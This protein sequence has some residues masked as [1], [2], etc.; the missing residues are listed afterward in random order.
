MPRLD[1]LRLDVLRLDV[2][3]LDVPR[4]DVLRLD[5]RSDASRL[6][7]L[8]LDIAGLDVWELGVLSR[9]WLLDPGAALGGSAPDVMG[10]LRR[11]VLRGEDLWLEELALERSVEEDWPESGRPV[12]TFDSG[13]IMSLSLREELESELM[14]YEDMLPRVWSLQRPEYGE[15]QL[16]NA[17]VGPCVQPFREELA[18]LGETS[19]LERQYHDDLNDAL[20]LRNQLRMLVH[21]EARRS[22]AKRL[23][24]APE[25]KKKR[26]CAPRSSKPTQALKQW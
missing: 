24:P 26:R 15:R 4:L 10:F 3:R 13:E 19:L 5:I 21:W 14:L 22:V 7:V 2:P 25:L 18:T 12:E 20:R 6:D 17:V 1:V 11:K 16:A 23:M 8:P 9:E